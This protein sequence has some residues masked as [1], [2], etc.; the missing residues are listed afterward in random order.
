MIKEALKWE[1]YEEPHLNEI[2][3]FLRVR[4][5]LDPLGYMVS[6][7]DANFAVSTGSEALRPAGSPS[8]G[9]TRDTH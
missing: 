5:F 3:V 4:V 8:D 7:A 6:F 2:F 1:Y 9:P